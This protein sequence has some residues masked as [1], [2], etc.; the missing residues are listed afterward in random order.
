ML[1]GDPTKRNFTS[2]REGLAINFACIGAG[3]SETNGIPNYGC[4]GGLRAQVFFPSCWNGRDLDS[5]DHKS[6]VS[7]PVRRPNEGPCPADFPV[8]LIS[9]FYEVLYDTPQFD[10]E[11]E[12]DQ[13]PFVF[14]NGDP[15]GF[16]QFSITD[17]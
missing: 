3:K 17:V 10:S 7:Y 15:T 11:W 4:P 1:A 16:G 13:H 8:H 14:S 5:P 9:I 2:D 6:H 12:G